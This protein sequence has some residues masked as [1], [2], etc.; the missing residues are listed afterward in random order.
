M[1][2]KPTLGDLSSYNIY[3]C[4]RMIGACHGTVKI[5]W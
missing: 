5:L 1:D 3:S 2:L 4:I